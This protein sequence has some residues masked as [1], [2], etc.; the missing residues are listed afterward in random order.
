MERRKAGTPEELFGQS[1]VKHSPWIEA[2]D[3]DWGDLTEGLKL[4]SYKK[5]EIIYHQEE[6]KPFVYLVKTG[7]VRLDV[8]SEAGNKRS[9]FVAGPGAMFGELSPIDQMPCFCDA[10]AAVD[11]V[12]YL[13]P[14]PLFTQRME[15]DHQFA[16][17][18]L[19]LMARKTRLMT[20]AIKQLSFHSSTSRVAYALINLSIQYSLQRPDGSLRLTMK[21]TQQEMADITGLSRVSVSNIFIELMSEGILEKEEG[22]LVIRD[23]TRL[24]EK[25]L[26]SE[27]DR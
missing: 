1:D 15:S 5:G 11:S 7:R 12:V 16:K 24:Y 22:F 23:K 21:F 20:D 13:I 27:V 26:K 18:L 3:I 2:K 4:I 8:Y 9:L 25:C 6:Q 19:L 17:N 10:T 14:T